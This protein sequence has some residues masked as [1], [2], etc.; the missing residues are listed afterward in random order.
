MASAP[1]RPVLYETDAIN[2][3][4]TGSFQLGTNY[5]ILGA[6]QSMPAKKKRKTNKRYGKKRA[7]QEIRLRR[8]RRRNILFSIL[9]I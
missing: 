4:P 6:M 7:P 5:N 2:G 9:V 3:V 8:I 1:L